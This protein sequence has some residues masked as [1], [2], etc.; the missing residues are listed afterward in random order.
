MS[1]NFLFLFKEIENCRIT[2]YGC[3]ICKK[4]ISDDSFKKY[5][6]YIQDL[7]VNGYS[8]ILVNKTTKYKEHIIYFSEILCF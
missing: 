5:F 7:W 2:F 1:F 4:I 8:G 3:D 6:P